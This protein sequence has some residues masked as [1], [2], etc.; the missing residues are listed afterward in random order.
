VPDEVTGL[1]L[2]EYLDAIEHGLARG[3]PAAL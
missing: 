1:Q 3:Q 2:R